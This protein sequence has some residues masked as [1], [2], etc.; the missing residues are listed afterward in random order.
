MGVA[1]MAQDFQEI[2]DFLGNPVFLEIL[3]LPDF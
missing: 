1:R 3:D 2:L